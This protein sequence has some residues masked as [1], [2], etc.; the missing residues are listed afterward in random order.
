MT[1]LKLH[2]ELKG[3][4]VTDIHIYMTS[5]ISSQDVFQEEESE[6]SRVVDIIVGDEFLRVF[7]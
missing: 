2:R 5:G 1:C 6:V 7:I 4:D 3:V